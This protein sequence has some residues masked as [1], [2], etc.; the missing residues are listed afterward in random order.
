MGCMFALL[1][2]Q[3]PLEDVCTLGNVQV[4]LTPRLSNASEI[5]QEGL[6]DLMMY[7]DTSATFSANCEHQ[8]QI[9]HHY[10]TRP[11]NEASSNSV[12]RVRGPSKQG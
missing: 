12:Q 2:V 11:A 9:R 4:G 6:V 10:M 8:S 3:Y 5:N 1:Y 7:D